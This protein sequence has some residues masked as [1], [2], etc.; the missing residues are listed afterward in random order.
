MIFLLQHLGF[1]I[2]LKKCVLG[3]VQE[4]EFLGLVMN[5]QT[6]TLSLPKKKYGGLLLPIK[7]NK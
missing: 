5:S 6:T 4:I 3:P 1:V 7:I 2:N